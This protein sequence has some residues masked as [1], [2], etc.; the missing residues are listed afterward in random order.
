MT[1]MGIAEPDA[2]VAAHARIAAELGLPPQ[3]SETALRVA[4]READHL[5]DDIYDVPAALLFALGRTRRCFS[6]F[7][8]M[9]V[10]VVMF[11]AKALG[12]RLE[13]SPIALGALLTRIARRD[14]EFDEVRQTVAAHLFPFGG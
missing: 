6:A 11:H 14:V 10:L 2:L 5:S 7:R 13:L 1:A 9:T 4:L 8:A 12:F 3:A